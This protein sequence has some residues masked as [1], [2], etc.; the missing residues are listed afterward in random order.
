[1]IIDSP[2][3][4]ISE[5]E[6]RVQF[7]GF[8]Q[9]IYELSENELLGTQVILIDKEYCPPPVGFDMSL[10]ETRYMTPDNNE[11]PPLIRNYRGL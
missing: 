3:K 11:F 9:L 10:M 7:E 4:N 1:M 8:H 2:M 5:R 6:N